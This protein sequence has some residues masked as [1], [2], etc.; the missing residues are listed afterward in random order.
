[1]PI[2]FVLSATGGTTVSLPPVQVGDL[3]VACAFRRDDSA[4]PSLAAGYTSAFTYLINEHGF[5]I[6]YRIATSTSTSGGTWT[7]SNGTILTVY[8]GDFDVNN[9]IGNHAEDAWQTPNRPV[10]YEAVNAAEPG[11]WMAA[12]GCIVV[13]NASIETPP[14][15]MVFRDKY[16]GTGSEVAY[17]DSNSVDLSFPTTTVSVGGSGGNWR[18]TVFEIRSTPK[19]GILDKTLADDTV[20]S[21]A[22]K[23]RDADLSS[24]LA[25]DVLSSTGIGPR[26]GSVSV[27]LADDTVISQGDLGMF[28][29]V[30]K[31]LA[32]DTLSSSGYVQKNANLDS[33]LSNDTASS[34][35]IHGLE[36]NLSV[37]L[38][39]D[40]LTG[41]G[42][43]GASG[44]VVKTLDNDT[45]SSSGLLQRSAS[46][47]STLSDDTIV[48][49]GSLEKFG[50][51]LGDLSNDTL[52]ALGDF[53]PFGSLS[54]ILADDTMVGT[55]QL[56]ITGSLASI[57]DDDYTVHFTQTI[58][59]CCRPKLCQID[60]FDLVCSLVNQLP[61]GPLWDM[62]KIR[63]IEKFKIRHESV[64]PVFFE[65]KCISI[66]DHAVYTA[67]RLYSALLGP[68]WSSIRE[69]NPYTAFDTLDDWLDRYRWV[70]CYYGPCRDPDL[71]DLPFEKTEDCV[72]YFCDLTAPDDLKLAVKHGLVVSLSRLQL[73]TFARVEDIN[74]I[75][76]PLGARL[77]VSTETL[78]CPVAFNLVPL[79][80]YLPSWDRDVCDGVAST[81]IQASFTIDDCPDEGE[82]LVFWP[83]LM[84]AECIVRSIMPRNQ[85]IIINRIM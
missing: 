30:D 49:T 33:T 34:S 11:S 44:S 13:T 73:G 82:S 54:S 67:E 63:A 75:I 83:G 61:T 60:K 8:R 38:D 23:G 21:T 69:S 65:E 62:P 9:P 46:V 31:I 10:T 48:S 15:G 47:V 56:F 37:I 77:Q 64:E 70:D 25:D 55:G 81:P 32:N 85:G 14:T 68:L 53:D 29:S 50:Q 17:H 22:V 19:T 3:I 79:S 4:L 35:G 80:N 78:D 42:S 41:N 58:E 26:R 57:L 36:G 2:S 39:D 1:M 40:I 6:A 5:R 12:F 74:W 18:T 84:S 76:E 59:E 71:G 51:V 43:E 16:L 52:T 72:N 28:G 27:T 66:A 45:I 24:I 20:S 7:N